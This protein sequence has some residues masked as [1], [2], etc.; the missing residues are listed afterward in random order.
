MINRITMIVLMVTVGMATLV[1]AAATAPTRVLRLKNMVTTRERTVF[2]RDLVTNRAVLTG[3]EADYEIFKTPV[4]GDVTMSIV[5]IAY[6]LQKYPSLMTTRLKG[7]RNI[8]FK[9]VTDM[10]SLDQA[11]KLM[12]RYLK[13]R[14][15]W[16]DWDI[17]VVFSP[18]DETLISRMGTFSRM[19]AEPTDSR[20]MIGTVDFRVSFYDEHDRLIGKLNL[21]PKILCR[22]E[23]YVMRESRAK[24]HV[25]TAADLKAV[26]IWLGDEK[27]GLITD[28]KAGIGKELAKGLTAGDYLRTVDL[29][30]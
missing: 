5:D 18:N 3:E 6:M 13:G 21:S 24:G 20:S 29:L 4:D 14:A 15:P 26:P 1:R 30:N 22:A 10:Y 7:E 2:L 23:A 17:D 27:K 11:K 8:V 9:H 16:R 28:K 12:V 19:E 25:L